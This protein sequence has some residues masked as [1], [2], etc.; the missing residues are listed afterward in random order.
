M[1]TKANIGLLGGCASPR[2]VSAHDRSFAR[3][4][5]RVRTR[6]VSSMKSSPLSMPHRRPCRAPHGHAAT[7]YGYPVLSSPG[8]VP[9]QIPLRH[10]VSQSETISAPCQCRTLRRG[11]EAV[12]GPYSTSAPLHTTQHERGDTEHE[13]P[14][15]E[16]VSRPCRQDHPGL[17]S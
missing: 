12:H 11:L 3:S 15:H 8:T 4:S 9:S 17:R 10:A 5:M 7:G 16:Q 6:R 2:P 13:A 1:Y 14:R